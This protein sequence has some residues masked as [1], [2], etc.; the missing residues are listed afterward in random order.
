MTNSQITYVISTK[1]GYSLNAWISLSEITLINLGQMGNIYTDP[2]RIR[3]KFNM[4]SGNMEIV[5]GNIVNN[6][7]VSEAGE[8]SNYTP[9]SFTDFDSIIGFIKS[10]HPGHQG[11]Y[12][13][14]YFGSYI[15]YKNN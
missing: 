4:T 13:K 1:Y 14:K 6:V 10:V 7:F 15:N 2:S 9:Q 11:T 3:I 12:Y 8:S 5:Y